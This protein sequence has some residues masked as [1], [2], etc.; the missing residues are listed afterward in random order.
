MKKFLILS[1][2]ILSSCGY[3]PLYTNKNSENLTFNKINLIGNKTI[4]RKIVSVLNF[5]EKDSNYSYDELALSSKKNIRVTSRND[6]GQATS[7]N[8]TVEA[9]IIFK[10]DDK[11]IKQKS[12]IVDFSYNTKDNKFDLAE[13]EKQVE[14]NLVDEV[15]EKLIIYINL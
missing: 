15:I 13:H 1:F 14:N 9:L 2:L 6:K 7:Y 10:R 12:F 11:I 4:N 5:T 3:Q 8:Q